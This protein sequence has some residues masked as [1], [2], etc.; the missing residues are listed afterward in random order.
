VS[1][2]LTIVTTMASDEREVNR[3]TIHPM[4]SSSLD[5]SRSSEMSVFAGGR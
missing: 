3:N 4:T 1:A 2:E 5:L